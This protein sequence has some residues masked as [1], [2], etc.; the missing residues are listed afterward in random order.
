MAAKKKMI[1]REI[2]GKI[3]RKLD[4]LLAVFGFGEKQHMS[5]REM[6][7]DAKETARRFRERQAKKKMLKEQEGK[8]SNILTHG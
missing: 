1:D 4:L 5:P 3:N 2:L 8:Q 6:E 7:A